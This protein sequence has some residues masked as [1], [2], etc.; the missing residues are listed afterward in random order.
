[1]I[2]ILYKGNHQVPVFDGK[3]V[4]KKAVTDETCHKI[5]PRP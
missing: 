5:I 2:V 3:E 4:T 1:M